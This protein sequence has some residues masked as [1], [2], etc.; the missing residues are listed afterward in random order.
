MPIVTLATPADAAASHTVIDAFADEFKKV[1]GLPYTPY[2]A[3]GGNAGLPAAARAAVHDVTMLNPAV[4]PKVIV[5]DGSMATDHVRGEVA[6]VVAAGGPVGAAAANIAIVQAMGAIDYGVTNN[7]T[8]FHNNTL[9][10]CI[11]QLAEIATG[12]TVSILYDDTNASSVSIQAYLAAHPAGKNLRFY[13]VAQLTA[14]PTLIDNSTVMLI[15]APTLYNARAAIKTLVHGRLSVPGRNVYAVYPEREYKNAHPMRSRH[16]IKVHGHLAAFTFR[17]AAHLAERILRGRY[18]VA[19]RNLPA[20]Q[21]AE[22]D[23]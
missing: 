21:E 1:L 3:A 14:N 10:T 6:A 8:G 13:T 12:A 23:E 20:M 9:Q 2:F 11:E 15:P 19:A 18:S 17:K 7:V 22:Q 5:T 16:R 4:T